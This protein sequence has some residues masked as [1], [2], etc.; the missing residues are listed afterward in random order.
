[1]AYRLPL[2]E[3]V[4]DGVRRCAREEL[5]AAITGLREGDDP[6]TAVHEARKS[7]KKLRA[8]VR[9]VAPAVPGKAR[10]DIDRALRDA[11]RLM[12]GARDADVVVAVVDAVAERYA[13]HVPGTAFDELRA[14]LGERAEAARAASGG[15][16]APPGAIEALE[17]IGRDVDAWPV[18]DA[19]WDVVREAASRTYARGVE[20]MAEAVDDPTVDALH[21]WRKRVK[22]LW[23][24][25]RLLADLWPDVLE[26]QA[27][28]TKVLSEHLGDDHDAAVLAELLRGD[29][30][31]TIDP[32]ADVEEVLPLLD[33]R[34][35]ELQADA[36]RLGMLIYAERPKAF[37]R[38][39][40]RWLDVAVG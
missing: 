34:R 14:R 40:G 24:H 26:A 2:D 5:E 1:M 8:L 28:Q 25:Q 9:L 19:D 35:E 23:Y 4:P 39:L 30:G 32:K 20:A 31:L 6:V 17:A 16:A 15:A 10:K 37:D 11:G 13:G 29:H 33:R 3:P 27:A 7:V 12:S 18:D 36:L 38:R 22:D 21:D